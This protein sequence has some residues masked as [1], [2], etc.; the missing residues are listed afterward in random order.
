MVEGRGV[1]RVGKGE[2]GRGGGRER[3]GEVGVEGR[4][5][6]R[7][8]KGEEGRGGG[9]RERWGEGVEGGRERWGWKGDVLTIAPR[10]A[11]SIGDRLG[12]QTC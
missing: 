12:K 3:R 11:P 5:G 4:G 6:E 8:W 2:V 9:G 1:E 7:G 10:V